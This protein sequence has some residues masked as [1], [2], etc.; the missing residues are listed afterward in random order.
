[1]NRPP[2]ELEARA[3]MRLYYKPELSDEARK[4]IEELS[5]EAR[6]HELPANGRARVSSNAVELPSTPLRRDVP[7]SSHEDHFF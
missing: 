4:H 3:P 7:H 6:K 5:D 1:M 2:Q